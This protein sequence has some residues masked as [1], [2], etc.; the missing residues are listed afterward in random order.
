MD[1]F[2]EF[3]KSHSDIVYNALQGRI[4]GS[5]I[6]SSM[7]R[8]FI[9]RRGFYLRPGMV[10]LTA[11]LFGATE[12]KAL[13]PA[14]AIQLSNEWMLIHDDIEDKAAMRRGGPALHMM[15][16]E[17]LALNAG[18]FLQA[19]S[20]HA[21]CEFMAESDKHTARAMYNKFYDIMRTTVFA[22]GLD[23]Q[24]SHSAVAL[25]SMNEEVYYEIAAGKG[26]YYSVYGPMQMGAI[27]AKQGTRVLDAIQKI[28]KPAGVAAQIQND[29]L[30]MTESMKSGRRYQDLYEGKITPMLINTFACSDVGERDMMKRVY[31]KQQEAKTEEDISMLLHLNE[32]YKS[33]DYAAKKRDYYGLQAEKMLDKYD[34]LLPNNEFKEIFKAAIIAQ[35]K[36]YQH[37]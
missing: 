20:W 37:T 9:N 34:K 19:E 27:V 24:F 3:V 7:A 17:E 26:S 33:L 8:E 15:F 10:F 28:A 5:D 12:E 29:I 25:D 2:I 6:N 4:N 18:D 22:Q 36:N 16:G 1:K 13:L 35:Y 30:D 23:L 11:M 31:A 32:K 21:L 14:I